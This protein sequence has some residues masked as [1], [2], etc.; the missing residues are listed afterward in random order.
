M[1][2]ILIKYIYNQKNKKFKIKI[3]IIEELND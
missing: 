1:E 3:L 2:I